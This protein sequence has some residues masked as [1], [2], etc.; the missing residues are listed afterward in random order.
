MTAIDDLLNS[1]SIVMYPASV[2]AIWNELEPLYQ[3]IATVT[4][5]ES[6]I[7]LGQQIGRKA[8]R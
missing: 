8:L 4:A 7:Q 2:V 5:A 6:L 3:S 1:S